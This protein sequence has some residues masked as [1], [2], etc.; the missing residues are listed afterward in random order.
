MLT[1]RSIE[2]RLEKV[3]ALR[4]LSIWW[5]DRKAT[6]WQRR[7]PGRPFSDYYVAHV[8]RHLDRG[9]PHPTLGNQGFDH[10]VGTKIGWDQANFA[11]RGRNAWR[12]YLAAGVEPWMR[13]VDYGCG[14]LRVGQ[15]A[16]RFA[17]RG[18]YWGIDVSQSFIDDGRKLVDPSLIEDKRPQMSVISDELINLIA[19]WEPQFIFSHTVLQHVPEA[20]LEAYFKRLAI[21]MGPACRAVLEFVAAPRTQRHKAMSW[22]YSDAHLYAI[23]AKADP[24]WSIAF[25]AVAEGDSKVMRKPRRVMILE[26]AVEKIALARWGGTIRRGHAPRRAWPIALACGS[27]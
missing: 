16:I 15:H 17:E 19:V 21:M 1:K 4:K 5:A 26:R 25:E 6:S 22:A 2:K 3:S 23:A 9:R 13:I 12:E 27:A 14:S 10:E 7:N 18:N 20:E 11:T 8:R 24:T